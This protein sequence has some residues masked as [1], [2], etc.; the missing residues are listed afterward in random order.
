MPFGDYFDETEDNILFAQSNT[1]SSRYN[2]PKLTFVDAIDSAQLENYD[3]VDV[4]SKVI[5]TAA[6]THHQYTTKIQTEYFV[7]LYNEHVKELDLFHDKC[8][9]QI[10][11]AK[12][13]TPLFDRVADLSVKNRL[14][15]DPHMFAS[16]AYVLDNNR[17]VIGGGGID[18]DKGLP[19]L[20]K[21]I[22]NTKVH[23]LNSTSAGTSQYEYIKNLDDKTKTW[24][25]TPLMM[26]SQTWNLIYANCVIPLQILFDSM[27]KIS[28]DIMYLKTVLSNH[29]L[30]NTKVHFIAFES[31]RL[32]LGKLYKYIKDFYA[33]LIHVYESMQK[34]ADNDI[35]IYE[36]DRFSASIIMNEEEEEDSQKLVNTLY[37][38]LFCLDGC[39]E[40][41]TSTVT[42]LG[43]ILNKFFFPGHTG[44]NTVGK[45]TRSFWPWSGPT[46]YETRMKGESHKLCFTLFEY[47]FE[48]EDFLAEFSTAVHI[49]DIEQG[50]TSPDEL[51]NSLVVLNNNYGPDSIVPIIGQDIYETLY[52]NK[53]RNILT[54][55]MY[56]KL[57]SIRDKLTGVKK[58]NS[59]P[60]AYGILLLPNLS[61]NV[62]N[63][64]VTD[65]L[66]NNEEIDLIAEDETIFDKSSTRNIPPIY[67][68]EIPDDETDKL[69]EHIAIMDNLWFT[70]T[71]PYRM[72]YTTID[73][74]TLSTG[75]VVDNK[76]D[77]S[78]KD[79][80]SGNTSNAKRNLVYRTGAKSSLF[81]YL[82][83]WVNS[84]QAYN[85]SNVQKYRY[86]AKLIFDS[87]T[88][89]TANEIE[90]SK[91]K[92]T[93]EL[94]VALLRW[95]VSPNTGSEADDELARYTYSRTFPKN[96][97]RYY[98]PYY[99]DSP[100]KS[101]LSSIYGKCDTFDVEGEPSSVKNARKIGKLV[102]YGS[103]L[104]FIPAAVI[105]SL[106]GYI[107]SKI[108]RWVTE[109]FGTSIS[110][111]MD[112]IYGLI[113]SQYREQIANFFISVMG[114]VYL[115]CG[116]EFS[117]RYAL[118]GAGKLLVH[119]ARLILGHYLSLKLPALLTRL[120]LSS[121][122]RAFVSGLLVVQKAI[123]VDG[124]Q[125]TLEIL[126]DKVLEKVN[127]L[128]DNPSDKEKRDVYLLRMQNKRILWPI[129][130]FIYSFFSTISDL[131]VGSY[132]YDLIAWVLDIFLVDPLKLKPKD[133]SFE[134]DRQPTQNQSIPVEEEGNEARGTQPRTKQP[135]EPP[136]NKEDDED[137]TSR[138]RP[139]PTENGD[140][141]DGSRRSKP[142]PD[143]E[144][145]EEAG[146]RPRTKQPIS[147]ESKVNKNYDIF[148]SLNDFITT[149]LKSKT[150]PSTPINQNTTSTNNN[151]QNEDIPITAEDFNVIYAKISQKSPT[152]VTSE[153]T[154]PPLIPSTLFAR[155]TPV[156]IGTTS[157]PVYSLE[158]IE[159][160][161]SSIITPVPPNYN[162]SQVFDFNY[163]STIGSLLS[164]NLR[165]ILGDNDKIGW[166]AFIDRIRLYAQK[167]TDTDIDTDLQNLDDI[168]K[169]SFKA[170]V[171]NLR[172]DDTLSSADIFKNLTP[173][174]KLSLRQLIGDLQF[175]H[176]FHGKDTDNYVS[177]PTV[178]TSGLEEYQNYSLRFF[179]RSQTFS[180]ENTESVSSTNAVGAFM[181]LGA[182]K[183]TLLPTT[184]AEMRNMFKKK[185]DVSDTSTYLDITKNYVS[186]LGT[187]SIIIL[188]AFT[189][190]TGIGMFTGRTNGGQINIP[191][192]TL[193]KNF[194]NLNKF[195][196]TGL[197]SG[198][199][200]VFSNVFSNA[201]PPTPVTTTGQPTV[202]QILNRQFF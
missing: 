135:E 128:K 74:D 36:E 85:E 124:Q 41:R 53:Q 42:N 187:P 125:L 21:N 25:S 64:V 149:W 167:R 72:A 127:P 139:K 177:N 129:A 196:V 110:F 130:E 104:Y 45:Y 195:T 164:F 103:A 194:N 9:L 170:I 69:P 120:V 100:W 143:V 188:T 122:Y 68:I 112:I 40:V 1:I 138:P 17:S 150:R 11:K 133:I 116:K 34:T 137:I 15:T 28:D 184:T 175:N 153:V 47:M 145:E 202:Q 52:K 33:F 90:I 7:R 82:D 131:V 106:Y 22:K 70:K 113:G 49:K 161:G 54:N 148:S 62:L 160:F 190:M 60:Y 27:E 55:S 166:E 24:L 168:N 132:V 155:Q 176:V 158:G 78:T 97:P 95:K 77:L 108:G 197:A 151:T 134:N 81:S 59:I 99:S 35:N 123:G 147:N 141:E 96:T 201:Q 56:L 5:M 179:E 18:V 87:K 182:L 13:F 44:T 117:T 75:K 174:D 107:Y 118:A 76:V 50:V 88:S 185:T 86:N 46:Q 189:F 26:V 142:P 115:I 79:L 180:P 63:A 191:G 126:V 186:S 48:F 181:L 172:T 178:V 10:I 162:W 6:K 12:F 193:E 39:S 102:A 66:S 169:S 152:L 71:Y 80:F 14:Y 198:F 146:T 105:K 73:L 37:Q 29:D 32:L 154:A 119:G 20:T 192:R 19:T 61:K 3:N 157:S 163:D 93:M 136:Q 140:D 183:Q 16:H 91:N 57:A 199:T 101:Q 98:R 65:M 38:F 111:F 4:A 94:K 114:F 23:V 173:S 92:N 51:H 84:K 165:N 159:G 67:T 156:D 144:N 2:A 89:D 58:P 121:I 171:D 43:H 109:T 8:Y 30:L 31:S 200:S 83:K